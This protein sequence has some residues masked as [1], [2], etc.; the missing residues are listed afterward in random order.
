MGPSPGSQ[1]GDPV[2]GAG[3]AGSSHSLSKSMGPMLEP[4]W[5]WGDR[6]ELSPPLG[7]P[8]NLPGLG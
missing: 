3:S 8:E 2:G 7:S 5:A 6:R 1:A 4:R